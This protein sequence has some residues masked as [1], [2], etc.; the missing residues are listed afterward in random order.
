MGS[1]DTFAGLRP[2]LLSLAYRML[3]AGTDAEDIVQEAWIRWRDVDE[4][5]VRSPRGWLSTVVGRLC[6]DRLKSIQ[7]RR[8]AY[9]GTWLPE[10][11][12]TDAPIDW[13]SISLA[14]LVVLE[15]LT[16]T[17]RAAFIMHQVFDYA[18][19]DVATALEMSEATA[20][21]A[22]HRAKKHLAANRP[23]FAPS[24][25]EHAR[26]LTAFASALAGRNLSELLSL[27]SE[28]AVL[29][30]DGGGK[31]RGAALRPVI[32]GEKVARFLVGLIDRSLIEPAL[33]WNVQA[34]NAWP[35]LVGRGS[36]GIVAVINIETDGK[37]IVAVRNLVNPDKLQLP[38][39]N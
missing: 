37:R 16:P 29:Y 7:T 21:Q 23:R 31:V 38:T 28:D 24:E 17:E 20:R 34:V 32:G 22:F 30:A 11:V 13:E 39:V 9:R 6:F 12:A 36:S 10:P 26:M 14:F 2:R 1:F 27:L 35:A 19:A 25:A 5:I 3:G 4:T 18:H 8:E 33:V 15:R